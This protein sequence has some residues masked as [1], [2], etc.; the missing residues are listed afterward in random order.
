MNEE[1]K[2][3]QIR[4]RIDEI[5]LEIQDLL[6]QRAAAAQ[7]VASI[8]LAE[9][10]DAV[11]YRPERE[12]QV[13]RQVKQRNKGPLSNNDMARLFREIMS[14][15]LA[16]EKPL[17]IA[18][19]GPQG[20]FTQAAASKHF[21]H[22]VRMQ[23]MTAISDVFDEVEA[24]TCDYGVVPVENSTEGVISHTLDMFIKSGLSI[25]GEVSLRINQNLM[26]NAKSLADV[27]VLYSHEQS[28]AQCRGWL[29]RHL[30][31]AERVAVN[32]NAEAARMAAADN[33]A[34][35]IAGENAA[36]LYQLNILERNIED[37]P[38]NTT[39]F[40]VIGKQQVPASGEDKTSLMLATKNEAGGL[41]ALLSPFAEHDISMTRIESRP[42]RRGIWD[43]VFFIDV[44]GHQDDAKVKL[45]FDQ[46]KKKASLFKVLGS[47]PVAVL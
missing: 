2:L 21:G 25:C 46:L 4:E 16:L 9:N 45:A 26:S 15:C 20:T 39:R 22:A 11:F 8:K 34:A 10:P 31:H 3:S 32:S 28:L 36:G 24:G 12:A 27:K 35:A 47:Y 42:S 23:P 18:Y 17:C 5:D 33:N 44:L 7:Q 38:G 41:H 37:E 13:L 40:L 14:T 1:E 29:D 30:S 19:L 43:Y 6:N